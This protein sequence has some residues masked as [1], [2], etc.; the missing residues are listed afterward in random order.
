MNWLKKYSKIYLIILFLAVASVGFCFAEI[1][2]GG[3]RKEYTTVEKKAISTKKQEPIYSIGAILA[4][5]KGIEEYKLGNYDKAIS[6]FKS[7][8]KQEPMFADAHFNLG[9]MYD[10]FEN[11]KSAIISFNRAYLIN[12]NDYEA[13][14]YMVK[15]YVKLGDKIAA[16]Y[17]LKKFPV[18]SEYYLKS[19]ELFN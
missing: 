2:E 16:K 10:Y 15:C 4:Y 5:N 3:I 18:E 14:Y 9:L 19:K 8:I 11:P 17:Y 13:L 12:K 7:A 1:I 6:S